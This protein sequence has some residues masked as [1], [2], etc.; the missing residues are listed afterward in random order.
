VERRIFLTAHRQVS[1]LANLLAE[2]AVFQIRK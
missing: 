2:I 1:A